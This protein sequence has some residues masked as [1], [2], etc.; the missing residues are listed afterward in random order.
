MLS[1]HFLNPTFSVQLCLRTL[2]L[3]ILRL[4]G[5]P[6][7]KVLEWH[8]MDII[9][10]FPLLLPKAKIVLFEDKFRDK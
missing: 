6:P 1:Y 4:L 8:A 5:L 2:I 10:F 7:P 3:Y 9:P